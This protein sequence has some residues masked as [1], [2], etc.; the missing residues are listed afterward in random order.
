MTRTMQGFI[1]V[2]PNGLMD[3]TSLAVSR[4]A[5]QFAVV[6]QS[7]DDGKLHTW[8]WWRARGWR[9]KPCEVMILSTAPETNEED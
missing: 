2:A 4:G 5:S 7:G 8:G 6:G 9:C 1:L 3:T